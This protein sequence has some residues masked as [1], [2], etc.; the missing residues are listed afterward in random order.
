M[1]AAGP[2]TPAPAPSVRPSAQVSA[3]GAGGQ[4]W[5]NLNSGKYFYQGSAHYGTTKH[6]QYMSE[7]E[8]RSKGYV[9]AKGQSTPQ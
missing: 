5:V 6:G 1:T 3:P 8:A 2:S 4:V 7:S 9:A